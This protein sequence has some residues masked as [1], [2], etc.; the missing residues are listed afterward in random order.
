MNPPD[1][2]N[3]YSEDSKLA[4]IYCFKIL[5]ERMSKDERE[6]LTLRFSKMEVDK[7]DVCPY[8]WSPVLSV[9]SGNVEFDQTFP[10]VQ[11]INK[12]RI[13]FPFDKN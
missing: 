10:N 5:F 2:F 4:R 11:F 13:R 1:K 9:I 3:K 6:Y 12:Q 7:F 8:G